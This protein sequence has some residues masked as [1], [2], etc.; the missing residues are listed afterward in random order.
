MGRHGWNLDQL[1]IELTQRKEIKGWIITEEHVH[2]REK[3]F[4]M[5]HGR[6]I[7]D[8]DRNVHSRNM[9]IKIMVHLPNRPDR[10]GEVSKKL[11]SALPL[12]EQID[13]AIE[14]A[15]QTDHQAWSLPTDF[16]KEI[17]TRVTTDPKMAED[18]EGVLNELTLKIE[19][20]VHKK[21]N[22]QFNSAELF[23]SV[24]DRELHLSNGLHHR[25]SQS[26]IYTEAAFSFSK[27]R[28]DQEL[29]SDEYLNS[30]WAVQTKD[31][32]IEKIFDEASERAENSLN[33]TKPLTGKY[34]VIIDSEVLLTL[35]HGH[36]TQLYA[37]NTYHG[38]P[39][40][41]PG[42]DFIPQASQDLLTITLDPTLEFGAGTTAVSEQGLIQAPLK[43]VDQNRVLATATDKQYGDYLKLKPNTVRGNVVIEPGKLSHQELTQQAPFVIEIL[44]FSGLFNDPNS[45]TF[46]SEIRLA[47]LYDNEKKKVTYIKG[48]SLS[49]AIQENFQGLKLSRNQVKRSHFSSDGLYGQGYF[50]PEFALLSDVSIVG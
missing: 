44:Q 42:M 17:P 50:G 23:L 39:F 40:I 29:E 12:N 28:K 41:K 31:L 20:A 33:V 7:T 13:S 43:L 32:P 4:M 19:G 26:R 11:F 36:L 45:G 35:L 9:A 38:L 18:I 24:H 22:T 15:L 6:L 49:G 14:S 5:E 1:K 25:S 47:K 3:Y 46:S 48:G 2:R 8:Q 34:S 10:Q 21:R 37:A 30:H 27:R 16:S